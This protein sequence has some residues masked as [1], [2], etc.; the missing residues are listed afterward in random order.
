MNR[1]TVAFFIA[2]ATIVAV[3][4]MYTS[5]GKSAMKESFTTTDTIDQLFKGVVSQFS[6][7]IEEKPLSNKAKVD[8][9]N[10]MELSIKA[11]ENNPSDVSIGDPDNIYDPK[12]DN[13]DNNDDN[14]DNDNYNDNDD[15]NDNDNDNDDNNDDDN[16][17]DND[18]DSSGNPNNINDPNN[19]NNLLYT[20]G[21]RVKL[22]ESVIEKLSTESGSSIINFMRDIQNYTNDGSLTIGFNVMDTSNPIEAVRGALLEN[23]NR[24]VR[25][26]LTPET[27]TSVV[28][29]DVVDK[30]YNWLSMETFVN[31]FDAYGSL[32]YGSF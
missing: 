25:D 21:E 23:A 22:A 20:I 14:N 11:I 12:N 6:T 9:I 15:D 4:I 13:D 8:I 5:F 1:V 7:A 18:N 27:T 16:D 2:V 19:D 10:F 26:D 31:E 30:Y 28:D 24:T 32:E 17:N 29:R 3:F